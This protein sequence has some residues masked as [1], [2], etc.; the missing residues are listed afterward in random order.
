MVCGVRKQLKLN[1]V[2]SVQPEPLSIS[3]FTKETSGIPVV[4]QWLTNPTRIHED[5]GSM[6]SLSALR[7]QCCW[8]LWCRLQMQLG[9]CVAVAVV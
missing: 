7:T 1:E 4:A 8:E 3:V 5:A 6:A 2:T 9:S